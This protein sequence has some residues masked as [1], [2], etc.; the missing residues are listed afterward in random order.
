MDSQDSTRAAPGIEDGDPRRAKRASI[1][2]QDKPLQG[3]MIDMQLRGRLKEAKR[4]EEEA[5]NTVNKKRCDREERRA[6]V[7]LRAYWESFPLPVQVSD[8]DEVGGEHRDT[9]ANCLPRHVP[10]MKC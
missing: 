3:R 10:R 7:Q 6:E 2:V 9:E 1:Q 8:V 5:E 4:K